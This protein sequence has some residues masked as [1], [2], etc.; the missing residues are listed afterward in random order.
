ML[1]R[2]PMVVLEDASETGPPLD[3][4]THFADARIGS[5]DAISQ[6][7]MVTLDVIVLR[8]LPYSMPKRPRSEENH[9]IQTLRFDCSDKS[10]R[11]GIQ[12]W[13]TY[14]KADH[15]NTFPG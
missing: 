5:W 14:G 13:C 11:I 15:F 7:L 9:S 8:E 3:S 2:R 6:S 10:L 1:G 4:Y 12:I